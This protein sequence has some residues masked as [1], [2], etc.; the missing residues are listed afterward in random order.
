[1]ARPWMDLGGQCG[2]SGMTAAPMGPPVSPGLQS[3]TIKSMMENPRARLSS[4]EPPHVPLQVED[5]ARSKTPPL[6]PQSPQ[7]H[8][9][10]VNSAPRLVKETLDASFSESEA[11]ERRVNQY[12]L[13]EEIGRGSFGRVFLGMDVNTGQEYALK[14]F[15]KTKLRKR[16]KSL[17][18][19]RERPPMSSHAAV[20]TGGGASG[21]GHAT[22]SAGALKRPMG[23]VKRP[24]ASDIHEQEVQND[25]LFLIRGEVAIMKKLDHENLVGLYE[26]LDDPK[27]DSLFMGELKSN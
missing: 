6:R 11:G 2:S 27:T 24:S 12:L 18:I 16:S 15:S 8:H 23:P 3:P 7:R 17:I 10:R 9:R 19:R 4:L 20:G 21:N 26:V 14:E 22:P 13:K 25:A 5:I 1:M